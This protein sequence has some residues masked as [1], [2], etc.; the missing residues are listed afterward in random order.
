MF[1]TKGVENCQMLVFNLLVTML[2]TLVSTIV[3]LAYYD[4][5]YVV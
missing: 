1:I 4:L 5:I 2:I 3:N